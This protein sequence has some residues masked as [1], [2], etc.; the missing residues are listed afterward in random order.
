MPGIKSKTR[1]SN[2]FS[3]R[4]PVL[5]LPWQGD[6]TLP[7][8]I[9][10]DDHRHRTIS[11]SLFRLRWGLRLAMAAVAVFF[12][13]LCAAQ[14]LSRSSHAAPQLPWP[15]ILWLNTVIILGS[16][17]CLQSGLRQFQLGK[18]TS[19]RW[20]WLGAALLG[21]LFLTG[22][23]RAWGELRQAGYYAAT[24][25]G[26]SFFYLL[27]VAHAVHILAGLILLILVTGLLWAGR[28]RAQSVLPG[29][30]AVLWHFLDGVW[31]FLLVWLWFLR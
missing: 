7:P 27:T 20:A 4:R 26:S 6:F 8:Y 22:Q 30:A 10:G 12:I 28:L 11:P 2:P 3:S 31:L 1:V 19:A 17:I 14:L 29:A 9:G 15:S 21:A 13:A 25:P 5:R 18:N 24:T 23:W 16:S